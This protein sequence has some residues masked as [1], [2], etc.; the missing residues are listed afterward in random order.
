MGCPKCK[1]T[2]FIEKDGVLVLC[3]CRYESADIQKYLNIPPRFLNAEFENYIPISPSQKLALEVCIHYVHT[4]DQREGKGL[5]FVGPS[6]MGKTHLAVAV[7]KNIYKLRKIRGFFFDTKDL[8]YR[9]QSYSND[10]YYKL[11]SFLLDVPLLILD[12]LGSERLSDWRIEVLSHIITHRYNFL[13]S[14]LITTNY[15]LNKQSQKEVA[16][17]LEERLSSGIVGKICQMNEVIYLTT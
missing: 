16:N 1:G 7:L 12:D 17:V 4:F 9:L 10:K 13:K 14:T 8:L 3:S 6:Q 11:M 15:P 2:G 5:T